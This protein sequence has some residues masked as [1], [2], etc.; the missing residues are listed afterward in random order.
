MKAQR[1][2]ARTEPKNGSALAQR[3]ALAVISGRRG[4]AEQVLLGRFLAPVFL[5][6]KMT[7][8]VT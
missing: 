1:T 4:S 8:K 2:A 5:I 7:Q 6:L 3:E